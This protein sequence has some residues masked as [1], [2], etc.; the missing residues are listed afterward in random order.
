MAIFSK[1]IYRFGA[2]PNKTLTQCFIDL[3]RAIPN[4]SGIP[5]NPG[6]LKLS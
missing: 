3:E 1:V 6:N 4:S 2:M 5:K